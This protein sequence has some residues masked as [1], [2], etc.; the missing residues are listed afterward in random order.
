MNKNIGWFSLIELTI[1]IFVMIIIIIWLSYTIVW[2]SEDFK[3]NQMQSYNKWWK[4]RSGCKSNI[5]KHGSN[6]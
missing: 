2:T 1:S 5:N 3:K 4:Y 6:K